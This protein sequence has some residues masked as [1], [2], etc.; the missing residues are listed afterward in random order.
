[1]TIRIQ[2]AAPGAVE[3]MEGAAQA[4]RDGAALGYCLVL[5]MADGTVQ[6][7]LFPASSVEQ[8]AGVMFA[9]MIRALSQS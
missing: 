3:A 9:S 6:R 1:M 7:Q 2:Q 4:L 5:E 8:T